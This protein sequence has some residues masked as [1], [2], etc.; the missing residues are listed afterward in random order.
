[1]DLNPE[2]TMLRVE[3]TYPEGFYRNI[4][5]LVK[6]IKNDGADVALLSF[7]QATDEWIEE[8]SLDKRGLVPAF[9]L[10]L[11]KNRD[12]MRTI[13]IEQQI[14]YLEP[15]HSDFPDEL[16][17]DYCHLKEDAHIVKAEL[18]AA[19]LAEEGLVPRQP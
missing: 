8:F 18:F 11:K 14:P 10:A 16:F 5:T 12:A 17:V 13:A 19:F 6:S 15:N 2:E 3:N 4:A 9:A 7:V 1:M